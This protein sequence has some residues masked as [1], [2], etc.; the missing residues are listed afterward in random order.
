MFFAGHEKIPVE[1]PRHGGYGLVL[2]TPI[3]PQP[4]STIAAVETCAVKPGPFQSLEP[5]DLSFGLPLAIG[6]LEDCLHDGL[7]LFQ[8]RDD[9]G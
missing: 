6:Q 1:L 5:G 9:G 4:G 3:R 7:I 2:M 8:R